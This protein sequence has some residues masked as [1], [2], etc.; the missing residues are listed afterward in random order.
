MLR[1]KVCLRF[2]DKKEWHLLGMRLKE[3]QLRRHEEQIVVTKSAGYALC[4]AARIEVQFQPFENL[5]ERSLGTQIES[6]DERVIG[7]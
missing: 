3:E 2:F 5:V 6:R 7:E 1:M 4:S